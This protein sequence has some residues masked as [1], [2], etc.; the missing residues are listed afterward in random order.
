M[1]KKT[2]LVKI[3]SMMK[4]TVYILECS[5]GSFYTGYTTDLERRYREHCQG[6]LKCKYTRAFPPRR[7]AASWQ[8]ESDLSLV[9]KIENMI[10]A[11]SRAKKEE[12]IKHP[13]MM[14]GY[15]DDLICF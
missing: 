15:Y 8:F 6:S 3:I 12:L 10:K 14:T 9:L 2:D 11:L 1:V 13:E 4:Y 5:N 7:I